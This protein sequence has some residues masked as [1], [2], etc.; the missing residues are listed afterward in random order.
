[1]DPEG[2]LW[3]MDQRGATTD[4]WSVFDQDGRWLGTVTLP[5]GRV[6]WIGDVVLTVRTDPD[7]DVETVKGYRL[8]RR[9]DRYGLDGGR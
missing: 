6:T 1:M 5:S 4:E 8:N 3:V 2:Y 7:T 9:A